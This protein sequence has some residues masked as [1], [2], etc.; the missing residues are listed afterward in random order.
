MSEIPWRPDASADRGEADPRVRAA[1]AAAYGG[2]GDYARAVAELCAARLMLPTVPAPAEA[3]PGASK[4]GGADEHDHGAGEGGDGHPSMAA[5]LLRSASG[6]KAV[7]VFTGADALAAWR[8]D[9]RPVRC[10]LDDV[11]ATAHETEATAILVDVAGPHPLVIEG[12]LVDELARGRR[13]VELPDGGFG[14]LWLDAGAAAPAPGDAGP[15]A[16][17][18]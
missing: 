14:W 5:V 17:V 8:A 18:P 16:P 9:A 12:P 15:G 7:C 6:Q 2:Q 11:A 3:E 4:R 13:L 1:L 10:T